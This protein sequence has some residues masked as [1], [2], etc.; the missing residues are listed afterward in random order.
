[1][2]APQAPLMTWV[3]N[4][5]FY[6]INLYLAILL[7]QIATAYLFVWD[8]FL[9]RRGVH[10]WSFVRKDLRRSNGCAWDTDSLLYY[11][12]YTQS[13]KL[14]HVDIQ[15]PRDSLLSSVGCSMSWDSRKDGAFVPAWELVIL[16]CMLPLSGQRS[17]SQRSYRQHTHRKYYRQLSI[18]RKL[19]LAIPL[20]LYAA[21]RC[22]DTFRG[23]AVITLSSSAWSSATPAAADPHR[24]GF[25][26]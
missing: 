21:T 6:S 25:R 4:S 14:Q 17:L 11:L 23:R 20:L 24:W 3:A 10:H 8:R 1:M 16:W 5:T 2:R 18:P 22:H 15:W 19:S 26:V 7:L 12:H 9:V 13:F